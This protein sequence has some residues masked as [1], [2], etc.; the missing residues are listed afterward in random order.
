MPPFA[1][2]TRRPSRGASLLLALTLASAASA[3]APDS[4]P[5]VP[6]RP[7]DAKALRIAAAADYQEDPKVFDKLDFE[8]AAVGNDPDLRLDLER[9]LT[10][11]LAA[12]ATTA[13]ARQAIAER[14]ARVIASDPSSRSPALSLLGPWLADPARQELARLALDRVPGRNIDAAYL[15]ALRQVEGPARIALAQSAGQRRLAKAAP[16]LAKFLK[17]D[18]RAL[19]DAAAAA[20]GAIATPR[21]FGILND[22]KTPVTDAVLQARLD[23]AARQPT[24]V[25][26]AT[27]RQLADDSS[28]PDV[29]RQ[30]AFRSLLATAPD[31]ATGLITG[32]LAGNDLSRRAVAL[33]GVVEL[34]GGDAIT[35]LIQAL[36][37]LDPATQAA[38]IAAF[39][40]R[41]DAAARPAV[42]AAS[43]QTAPEPRIAAIVALGELPGDAAS[44]R[45]LTDAILAGGPEAKAATQS[46]AILRGAGVRESIAEGARTG[47]PARRAV[48]IRQLGL[49]GA[50]SELGFLLGLRTDPAPLVRLASLEALDILASA[51]EEGALIA[52]AKG[53]ADPA[54][55]TRAVRTYLA[56]ALRAPDTPERTRALVRELETGDRTTQLLFLPALSRLANPE[57]VA[58]AG[59]LARSPDAEVAEAAFAVLARWPDSAAGDLLVGLASDRDTLRIRASDAATRLFERDAGAPTPGRVEALV[60]LLVLSTDATLLRRQLF[61]LSRAASPRALAAVERLAGN[62]AVAQEVED[63][64][65]AIRSNLAGA[66]LLTASD[67]VDHLP[68][69]LDG[70]PSTAW[71]VGS[72]QDSWLQIDLHS[73]RP[74]RRLTLDRGPHRNDIPDRYEVFV[75]DNPTEP[76]AARVTAEGAR[77]QSAIDLPAGIRGRY[78]IIRNR[79]NREDGKWSIAELRI[80]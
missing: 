25:A 76:G 68:R 26:S 75:T 42:I 34:K 55:R 23:A 40:R 6:T 74:V 9:K 41:G 31:E 64:L 60:Q 66:P 7:A 29:V 63:T 70:Q 19:A 1:F 56:A 13:A 37:R 79:G 39:A 77:D 35:P 53:A 52:W 51:T 47:D 45:R 4:P 67:R 71:S 24:K 61:L 80:D 16:I 2:V 44:V 27:Y 72:D 22:R 48:L 5:A 38:L 17:T 8:V 46:L 62:A 78:I 54:E 50:A 57:T 28:A 3:A 43:G 36:P 33:E 65:L 32:A 11:L 15:R 12:P 21:A 30:R 58:V 73:A 49:R 69:L 14:L 18:D 59:R 20:L 10:D